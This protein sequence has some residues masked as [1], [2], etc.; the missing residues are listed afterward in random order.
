MVADSLLYDERCHLPRTTAGPK[1]EP[2]PEV[3]AAQR[4]AT[5]PQQQQQEE[6]A[7][8]QQQQQDLQVANTE[9]Q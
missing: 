2:E 5:P 8:E 7:K 3:T 4:P 1:P 6:E 9:Q